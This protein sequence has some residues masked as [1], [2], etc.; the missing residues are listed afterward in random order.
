MH[1]DFVTNYGHPDSHLNAEGLKAF[2][3]W[4]PEYE[5]AWFETIDGIFELDKI[6]SGLL[7]TFSEVGKM[8]KRYH[9]VVNPND[10]IEKYGADCFR[11]YEMFLGPVEQSKPWDTMGIEGVSKFL[12]KF[13]SLYFNE[14]GEW[15][16]NHDEPHEDSM[17]ALH[18]TIKKTAEDIERFSFN[19]AISQF[20]ICVNELRKKEEH[21]AAILEPLANIIAPFAPFIAEEIWAEFGHSTSVHKALFPAHDEQWL[22]VTSVFYPVCINGKKRSEIEL[23]LGLANDVIEQKAKELPEIIKWIDGK[24]IRKVIIVPDKMINIVI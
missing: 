7:Y 23:P 15:I 14:E 2:V 24:P 3:K 11:M 16:V 5:N 22:T 21:S 13:W 17:R 18:A 12:R 10:V 4:R 8:S 9:N 1:I 19:T 6:G 20:M